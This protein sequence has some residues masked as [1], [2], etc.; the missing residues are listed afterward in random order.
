MTLYRR[1]FDRVFKENAVK[2][3][4]E[5]SCQKDFAA[6]LGI[7]PSILSR[8]REEYRKY[9]IG[10]F[11]GF[12]T[13]KVHPDN[14]IFFE[15]E[16]NNK[17][18]EI[19]LEIFKNGFPF[20]FQGKLVTYQFIRSNENKYSI[21]QMCEVL[22][23]CSRIYFKWKKHGIPK[24]HR[25]VT[26]LKEEITSIFLNSKKQYGRDR[27]TKELNNRG[28]KIAGRQ[29]SNYMQ[30]LGL[31]S[32]VKKKFKVTTDSKHNYYTSPNV[33]NRQFKVNSPSTAWVSDITYIQTKTG[34]LY[35]TIIMDLYDRKIIGWSLSSVMSTKKT[36]LAAWDMAVENRKVSD[37]LIFHSDRGVQYANKAF[38]AKLDSYKCIR[39]M[40]RKGDHLDNAVSESFFSSFKKELIH[41]KDVLLTKEKMEQEIFEYIENWYNKKRI[42]S[43]LNYQT[44]EQFN[45][46]VTLNKS[47]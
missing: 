41:R 13:P 17:K 14:K 33:L 45:D 25:E 2:L 36:T 6:E 8:W 10:S 29:V 44:I 34:F 16:K 7:W 1:R 19:K 40:N 28:Y 23:I 5:K 37:G 47:E 3:S 26:L 11:Q 39:S 22:G 21:D 38:T 18:S 9:G 32:R 12:G 30:E 46:N 42:H 43:V 4:Y 27:I 31:R 15:L 35:L 24:K 20:L